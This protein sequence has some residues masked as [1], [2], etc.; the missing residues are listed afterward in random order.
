MRKDWTDD[1]I[2]K[3]KNKIYYI[4]IVIVLG[5]DFFS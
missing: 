3:G 1:G 2:G 5:I 4:Y